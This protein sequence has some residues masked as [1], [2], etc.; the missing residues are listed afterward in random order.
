[1]GRLMFDDAECLLFVM[2]IYAGDD[3]KLV[4]EKS[5]LLSTMQVVSSELVL[6]LPEFHKPFEVHANA[7]DRAIGEDRLLYAKGG[8]AYVPSALLRHQLLRKTHNTQWARHSGMER[9]LA[10]Q[11][12][13]Y[14]WPKMEYDVETYVQT[15]FVCQFDKSECKKE[16]GGMA[17]IF[18]VVDKFS[19]L[20]QELLDEAKESLSKAQCQMKKYA[21]LGRWL[22]LGNIYTYHENALNEN[23]KQAMHAPPMIGQEFDKKLHWIL[24]HC[25]KRQS[26]KNRRMDYFVHW[27]SESEEDAI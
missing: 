27:K 6:K 9:V 10:L 16:V 17:S 19:K 2:G 8:R 7:S 24:K 11:S 22:V 13:R 23:G 12:C 1:M 5:R 14:Y 15:C 20:K 26:K 25:T 21:D 18:V 4:H 3:L